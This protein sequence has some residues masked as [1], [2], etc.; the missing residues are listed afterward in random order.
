MVAL[1]FYS[2]A[3]SLNSLNPSVSFPNRTIPWTGRFFL[4][5]TTDINE[6]FGSTS[7][8]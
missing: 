2:L 6:L 3:R 4:G 5:A 1:S 7:E 8:T